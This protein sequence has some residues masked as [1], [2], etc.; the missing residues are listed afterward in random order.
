MTVKEWFSKEQLT[1]LS[2]PTMERVVKLIEDED[3]TTSIKL[4]ESYKM[5]WSFLRKLML[6]SNEAVLQF[7]QSKSE[8]LQM[9]AM[10]ELVTMVWRPTLYSI[11]EDI[12]K[13][14]ATEVIKRWKSLGVNIKIR[15]L[16]STTINRYYIT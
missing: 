10:E 9:Q 16:S 13:K 8:E 5:E 15:N 11:D 4:T 2:Q 1:L 12:R 14:V 6:N 3:F 7:I